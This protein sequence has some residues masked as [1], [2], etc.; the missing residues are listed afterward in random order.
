MAMMEIQIE[1]RPTKLFFL[2]NF[3]LFW[4][5]MRLQCEELI[6]ACFVL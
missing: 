2:F 4:V 1:K 5:Q 3:G 6:S